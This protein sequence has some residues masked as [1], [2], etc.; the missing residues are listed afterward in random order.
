[1]DFSSLFQQNFNNFRWYIRTNFRASVHFPIIPEHL[2]QNHC[3]SDNFAYYKRQQTFFGFHLLNIQYENY[4]SASTA[5]LDI[6]PPALFF[7]TLKRPIYTWQCPFTKSEPHTECG[8]TN[9]IS[10]PKTETER[11]RERMGNPFRIFDF[12]RSLTQV[13]N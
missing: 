8:R 12:T 2:I 13:F 4:F 11:E 9:Q 10:L 3:W 6:L 7:R 5:R 1:M